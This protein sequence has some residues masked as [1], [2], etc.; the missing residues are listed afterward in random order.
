MEVASVSAAGTGEGNIPEGSEGKHSTSCHWGRCDRRSM[1]GRQK[2]TKEREVCWI[3]WCPCFLLSSTHPVISDIGENELI[4]SNSI[5]SGLLGSQQH[6][7][8]LSWWARVQVPLFITSQ[9]FALSAVSRRAPWCHLI[10]SEEL[11]M[12]AIYWWPLCL[13][14]LPQL[15]VQLS[16]LLSGQVVPLCE[17]VCL[18]FPP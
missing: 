3:F 12:G 16:A 17:C 15:L 13:F 7:S 5:F 18:S 10:P 14:S 11:W 2:D 1:K 6:R 8:D 9:A 4:C